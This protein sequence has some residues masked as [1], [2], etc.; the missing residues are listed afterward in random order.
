MPTAGW[1]L[2][3]LAV[4]DHAVQAVRGPRHL[5]INSQGLTD[6][7]KKNCKS[8]PPGANRVIVVTTGIVSVG[9]IQPLDLNSRSRW[10]SDCGQLDPAPVRHPSQRPGSW[11]LLL[12]DSS[13]SSSLTFG[14]LVAYPWR[15]VTMQAPSHPDS[16]P[17]ILHGLGLPKKKP[18]HGVTV[19]SHLRKK[20]KE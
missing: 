11:V 18:T 16:G 1:S 12:Q 9:R 6:A 3:L 7:R 2:P 20:L 8:G 14:G 15:F 10:E 4:L 5:Q 17:P 19:L 13:P